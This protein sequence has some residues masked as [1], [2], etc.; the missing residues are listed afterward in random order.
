VSPDMR[1]PQRLTG[2]ASLVGRVIGALATLGALV[3]GLMFSVVAFGVALVAGLAVWGWMWWKM[4]GLK[5][6][7]QQDPR[8]QQFRDMASGPDAMRPGE[9]NIIE[10][11]VLRGEWKD[12]PGRRG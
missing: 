9:G 7:M 10:G 5:R 8:Y 6:R 12:E 11:E 3:L 4:R 2:P 1:G